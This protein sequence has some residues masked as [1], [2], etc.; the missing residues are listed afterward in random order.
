MICSTLLAV[1]AGILGY[2]HGFFADTTKAYQQTNRRFLFERLESRAMMAQ[3]ESISEHLFEA[4]EYAPYDNIQFTAFATLSADELWEGR[5]IASPKDIEYVKD[6]THQILYQAVQG[7]YQFLHGAAIVEYKGMLYTA[8]AN[9]PVNEN[10]T[11]ELVRG[12]RSTDNGQ[13]W[14]DVE[15]IAPDLPGSSS[16]THGSFFKHN[17]QLWYFANRLVSNGPH[18]TDAFKLNEVTNTWEFAGVATSNFV[19]LDEPKRMDNGKWI[20]AGSASVAIFDENNILNWTVVRLNM[21]PGPALRFPES[22]VW[23]D[24]NE[25]VAITRNSN[26]NFAI[27]S[28]S[29]DYGVTW[30]QGEVSNYPMAASKPFAGTLSSGQRY[31]ISNIDGPRDTLTIAVSRPYEESLVRV[32]KIRHGES[33]QPLYP[34]DFNIKNSQWSYPY[35]IEHQG[36]LYVVYSAGKE[37]A[38]L[39]I[40]PI[41]SLLVDEIIASDNFETTTGSISDGTS[42]TGWT[43]DWS[44]SPNTQAQSDEVL[45]YNAGELHIDGGTKS[46]IHTT[47]NGNPQASR[48]FDEQTGVVYFSLLMRLPA[49]A[50]DEFIGFHFTNSGTGNLD[51]TPSMELGFY[52]TYVR[53][54][55]YNPAGGRNTSSN[56]YTPGQTVFVVGRISK[57]GSSGGSADEYDRLELFINPTSLKEP[58][59]ATRTVNF[60]STL[61]PLDT[62][63]VRTANFVSGE[64]VYFDEIRIGTSYASVVASLTPGDANF[65]NKVDNADLAIWQANYGRTSAERAHGDV[66]ND[67]DVDGRDFLVWQRNFGVSPSSLEAVVAEMEPQDTAPQLSRFFLPLE[68]IEPTALP[69]LGKSIDSNEQIDHNLV[70][71]WLFDKIVIS[72]AHDE[73]F[74]TIL[75]RKAIDVASLSSDELAD[76]MWDNIFTDFTSLKLQLS[77]Y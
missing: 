22:T 2:R 61:T 54:G 57:E 46:V 34:D 23:V 73:Y 10:S 4:A 62:F 11:E 53:A 16:R 42:G 59:L 17:G 72:E 6:V 33:P 67:G 18:P 32:W 70:D 50:T 65:D 35:A 13:T 60:A 43:G 63:A 24:G 75:N 41:D 19:P 15:I 1:L 21:P 45:E 40:F 74:I 8:W 26:Q 9:S 25:V 39:S 14:S 29:D 68:M 55:I 12:R 66:D 48:S 52:P 31:L 49:T 51:S 28:T 30:N 56:P 77:I 27:V 36:K 20:V 3:T 76:E 37:D 44:S 38:I 58:Q 71:E 5:T 47:S 7:E 64:S 69:K